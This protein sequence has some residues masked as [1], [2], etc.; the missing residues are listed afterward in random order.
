MTRSMSWTGAAFAVALAAMPAPSPA[1]ESGNA[2]R[3][4]GQVVVDPEQAERALERSLVQTGGLL[5]GR[6]RLELEPS[7]RHGRREIIDEDLD[8]FSVDLAIRRGLPFDSQLELGLPFHDV[9]GQDPATGATTTSAS[10]LGDLR[11]G[12]ARTLLREAGRRP[13]LIARVTW[14]T[15]TGKNRQYISSGFDELR[16]S[17]TAIK[18]QD[19][20]VFV[21]A[22]A[23]EHVLERDDVRPG[24]AIMPSF[25]AFVALSPQTSM[26]FILSQSFRQD[27]EIGGTREPGTEQTAATFSVGGSSLLDGDTLL[28]LA[29]DIGLTRDTDDYAVRLALPIRF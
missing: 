15:R 11:I 27:D 3:P 29:V 17:F 24:A 5:L 8:L 28:D 12:L 13:D 19:P 23:Y 1:Q 4:P 2:T 7:L 21:G 18:R 16:L 14:D 22:L 26:R 25:G 9:H 10:G 20:L 6:G